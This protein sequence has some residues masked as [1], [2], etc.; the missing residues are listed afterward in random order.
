MAEHFGPGGPRSYPTNCPKSE[1]GIA[2]PAALML[3]F[4][5]ASLAAALMTSAIAASGQSNRDRGVKRAVAAA[6]AGLEAAIYRINKLTPGSLKCIVRGVAGQLV[7]ESVQ[8]DGWCREQTENLGDGATY[9]YR[10]RAAVQAPVNGQQLL[11]RKI[12]STGT[13]NGVRRR[14]S[15]VIG[16]ATGVSL[17]GDYAVISLEDLPLSNSA[18]IEGNAGS[19]GDI[20]LFNSA[21]ICGNATPGPGKEFTA[22][23]SAGLCPGFVATPASEPFVLNP[24]D[25]GNTATV[26]D[27]SRIGVL[28]VLSKLVGVG[29]NLAT[30]AL[31]LDLG[32]TLTL[33]GNVYSFCSLQINNNSELRIPPRDPAVPLKIYIDSP[34]NCPGVPN[35]GSVILRNGG[36][37]VNMNSDPTTVQLYVAGSPATSTSVR[38]RTTSRQP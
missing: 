9:S 19:N 25:Q 34:E 28:D 18:R 11:Q 13:V 4:I 16:S 35:A 8:V 36:N 29:W 2:L 33:T 17:F 12:V 6:D 24:I 32:A 26:N 5:V 27:N 3:L 31:T 30:R 10:V 20:Y 23:N 22:A 38:Y 21:Q 1:Q 15:T 37:I 7:V 14:V